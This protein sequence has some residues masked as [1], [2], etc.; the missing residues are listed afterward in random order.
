MY[1]QHI[2]VPSFYRLIRICEAS[3]FLMHLL[4]CGPVFLQIS[5]FG[6]SF[7]G[8]II[9]MFPYTHDQEIVSVWFLMTE[10]S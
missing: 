7:T 9:L 10:I 1:V 8:T 2:C 3:F 4:N 6:S 5:L